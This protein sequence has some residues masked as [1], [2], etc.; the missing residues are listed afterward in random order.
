MVPRTR[1][2]I[3]PAGRPGIPPHQARQPAAGRLAGRHGNRPFMLTGLLMQTAGLACL[4]IIARRQTAFLE[5][6]PP[7]T[8]AGAGT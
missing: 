2:A 3:N 7:L 5:I 8:I 6:A 4:A 1:T